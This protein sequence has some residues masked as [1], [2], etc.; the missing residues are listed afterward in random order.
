MNFAIIGLNI[1]AIAAGIKTYKS[2]IK[3]KREKN[4]KT[5]LLAKS[6]S[7]SIEVIIAKVIITLVMM[8]L[9]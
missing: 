7:H 1:C 2:I 3:K 5:V 9:F 8:N 6:K 4:D